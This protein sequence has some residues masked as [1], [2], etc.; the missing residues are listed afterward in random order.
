MYWGPIF[1][2]RN[3]LSLLGQQSWTKSVENFALPYPQNAC[4]AD[5]VPLWPFPSP[6]PDQSCFVG[7]RNDPAGFQHFW[8]EKEEYL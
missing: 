5:M 6:H 8:R 1:L 4:P 3:P 2:L 7:I